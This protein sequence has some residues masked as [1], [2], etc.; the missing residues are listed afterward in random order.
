L[1]KVSFL[2]F[3]VDLIFLI[4][5]NVIF[6]LVGGTE[7]NAAVWLSYGFIHFA[8]IM[9]LLT[10]ILTTESHS[11]YVFGF[12]LGSISTAYFFIEFIIGLIFILSKPEDWTISFIVQIVIASIYAILLIFNMIANEHTAD[13]EAQ[14]QGDL[15]YIKNTAMQLKAVMESTSDI[16][17]K[18]LLEKAYDALKSSPTKSHRSVASLE[19]DMQMEIQSLERATRRNDEEQLRIHVNILQSKIAERNRTLKMLN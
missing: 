10:P 1:N 13:N 6:F 9:L 2:W 15:Q 12:A 19:S 4:V 18:K 14:S 11:A 7:H 5:F 3:V 17:C 8:Y 16:K